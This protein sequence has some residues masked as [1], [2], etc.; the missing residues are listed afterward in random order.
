[1]AEP[2]DAS[3]KPLEYEYAIDACDVFDKERLQKYRDKRRQWL[4]WLE[5]DRHHAIWHQ[6]LAMLWNDAVF[7]MIDKSREIA[8]RTQEPSCASS[9]PSFKR[10]LQLG[11]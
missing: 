8:R 11:W 4:D 10:C 7:R 5:G 6:I 1:M 2:R 9:I 3:D